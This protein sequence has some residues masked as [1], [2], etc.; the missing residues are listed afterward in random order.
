MQVGRWE[1]TVITLEENL[2]QATSQQGGL[3]EQVCI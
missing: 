1:S 3:D 2:M